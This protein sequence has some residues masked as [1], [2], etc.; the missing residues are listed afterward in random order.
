MT[1]RNHPV[2]LCSAALLVIVAG[3]VLP[4]RAQSEPVTELRTLTFNVWVGGNNVTDGLDK[5]IEAIEDSGVDVVAMQESNGVVG[6]FSGDYSEPDVLAPTD[7]NG[8]ATLV[9]AQTAGGKISFTFYLDDVQ[10][11]VVLFFGRQRQVLRFAINR[12]RQKIFG[13]ALGGHKVPARA[14]HHDDGTERPPRRR[15]Q[16]PQSTMGT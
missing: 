4:G 11:G 5:I 2:H 14:M 7:G 9:T 12:P 3:L 1:T 13:V 6:T 10:G 16:S 8:E 15:I